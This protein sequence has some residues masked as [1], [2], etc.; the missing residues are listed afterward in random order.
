MQALDDLQADLTTAFTAAEAQVTDLLAQL[1]GVQQDHV[2]CQ[3]QIGLPEAQIPARD[4]PD[5][6]RFELQGDA[7]GT[8]N[9]A[10]N[11][12]LSGLDTAF[13]QSGMG[14]TLPLPEIPGRYEVRA[15]FGDHALAN[16]FEVLPN[17]TRSHSLVLTSG[18][19]RV[20]FDDLLPEGYRHVVQVVLTPVGG[21][22]T[23]THSFLAGLDLSIPLA[24]GAYDMQVTAPGLDM[25][26]QVFVI[27]SDVTQV[28]LPWRGDWCSC[29][30]C[31]LRHFCPFRP[32]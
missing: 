19:L 9:P 11:W 6:V 28:I 14:Q 18:E 24:P 2:A 12:Q 20:E 8:L 25:I 10:M 4:G 7:I 15:L 1:D 5:T 17:Q 27:P 30:L 3:A 29:L 26:Q 13:E 16:T 21:G 31:I 32:L 22:E 23:L